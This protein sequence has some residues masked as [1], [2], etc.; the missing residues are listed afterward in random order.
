MKA[1]WFEQAGS[2]FDVLKFGEMKRPE[3][4]ADEVVIRVDFSAVNPT[5]VKRRSDGRELSRFSQIVPNNDGSGVIVAAGS[6]VDASRVDT[7]VWIF[8]AQA[9]RAMGTAAQYCVLPSSQAIALPDN[10]S[11]EEGACLGVPAVTAHRGLFSEG[12]IDGKTILIT[13][14]TGR[15]GMYAVQLARQAG[16]NVIAT[17]GSPEKVKRLATLG[18]HHCIN[19]KTENQVEAVNQITDGR[20]VDLMLDVT[21]GTNAT[22]AP[23]LVAENGAVTSYST[24]PVMTPSL[25]FNA[26]M[27][28]NILIRPFS[29]MRMPLK[30]KVAAFDHITMLLEQNTLNHR[31][32]G[33]FSFAQL[34]QAHQA[35]EQGDIDGV[36]VVSIDQSGD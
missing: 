16:A 21:F 32:G 17:A 4:K 29:I 10:T 36:C 14:G 13:G 5:D 35:V 12:P 1:W 27:F 11:L 23:S 30:A 15:V 25:D 6:N 9:G 7:R 8:A 33:R 19:Y 20:G 26:F 22:D 3:P 28:S 18:A 2:A 31:I 34:P 24:D